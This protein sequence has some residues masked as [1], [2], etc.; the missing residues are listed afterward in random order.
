MPSTGFLDRA[1]NRIP[2]QRSILL[3]VHTHQK[4]D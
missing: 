2:Q 3:Q 1:R 4:Q